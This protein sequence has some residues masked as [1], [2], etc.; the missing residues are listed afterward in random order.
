MK[1]EKDAITAGAV[2]EVDYP[3]V[4]QAYT[5]WTEDGPLD[6]KSWK[7][8]CAYEAT[9]NGGS[10]AYANGMGKMILTVIDVHTPGKYPTRV[11]YT[12]QWISPTGKAF[13]KGGL[14]ICTLEKFRRLA[15]RFMSHDRYFKYT[16]EAA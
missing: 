4:L 16:V 6:R 15:D 1:P 2:F 12:R 3:F 8:G 10:E 7:P 11:F 14:R 13:G 5:E 9:H